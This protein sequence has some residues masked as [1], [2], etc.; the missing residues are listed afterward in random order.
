M[1][2]SSNSKSDDDANSFRVVKDLINRTRFGDDSSIMKLIKYIKETEKV[3]VIKDYLIWLIWMLKVQWCFI[4]NATSWKNSIKNYYT[5][6]HSLYILV[7]P[8]VI[9][10]LF[11]EIF[12]LSEQFQKNNF[13]SIKSFCGTD[14][15]L[16]NIP[17]YVTLYFI[18]WIFCLYICLVKIA[19]SKF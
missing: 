16:I 9:S 5:L 14:S 10:I 15:T 2:G 3:I 8:S 19:F 6:L 12:K 17:K 7:I 13:L 18:I 11:Q 4:W 1:S